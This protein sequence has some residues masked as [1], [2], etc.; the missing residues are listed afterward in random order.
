M[1]KVVK[2]STSE[3]RIQVKEWQGRASVH[4]R[5]WFIPEDGKKWLPTKR[6]IVIPLSFWNEFVSSVTNLDVSK[7]EPEEDIQ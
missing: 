4:I 7:I 2:N 6:G 3:I 1:E 5:E